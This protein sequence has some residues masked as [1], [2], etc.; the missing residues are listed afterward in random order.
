MFFG[1][2]PLNSSNV[3]YY[4]HLFVLNN[5]CIPWINPTWSCYIV[6][7]LMCCWLRVF[8]GKFLHL[9]SSLF[10]AYNFIFFWCLYLA[11]NRDNIGLI[12]WVRKCSSFSFLEEFE[13]EQWTPLINF[14]FH[15]VYFLTPEFSIWFF[16]IIHM[17]L[18]IFLLF[19]ALLFP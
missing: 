1:F 6:I 3:I 4:M 8:S 2:F 5:S 16:Y 15:L 13:K 9:S 18:F 14:S 7:L 10:L 17:S 12:K 19:L 11:L